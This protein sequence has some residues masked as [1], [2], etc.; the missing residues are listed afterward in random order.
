LL[1][2]ESKRHD[3]MPAALLVRARALHELGNEPEAG[4][5]LARLGTAGKLP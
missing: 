2:P 1:E 4:E 5:L 3:A